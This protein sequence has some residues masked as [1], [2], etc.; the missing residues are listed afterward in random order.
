MLL[1]ICDTRVGRAYDAPAWPAGC[2]ARVSYSGA[3]DPELLRK[4]RSTNDTFSAVAR[5]QMGQSGEPTRKEFARWSAGRRLSRASGQF[6]LR[7]VGLPKSGFSLK[8][9][10]CVWNEGRPHGCEKNLYCVCLGFV[11]L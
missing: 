3:A 5:G 6:F 7:G 1:A 4:A 10:L 9:S 2:L 8:A 11:D